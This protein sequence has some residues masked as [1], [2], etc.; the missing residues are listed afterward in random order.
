MID[1]MQNERG[2]TSYP[3]STFKFLTT[4]TW[5]PL[6]CGTAAILVGLIYPI[7]DYYFAKRI[8]EKRLKF[9]NKPPKSAVRAAKV[10][11]LVALK[12]DKYILNQKKQKDL[13]IKNSSSSSTS[14]TLSNN[15]NIINKDK[16]IKNINDKIKRNSNFDD[17]SIVDN[18]I[19]RDSNTHGYECNSND[20]EEDDYYDDEYDDED[21]EDDEES[22]IFTPTG[23]MY[24]SNFGSENEEEEDE[25]EDD[26]E[27]EEEEDGDD[28]EEEHEE[29]DVRI[30]DEKENSNKFI[31]KEIWTNAFDDQWLLEH[32][33]EDE[34]YLNDLNY[35][36][37]LKY[38]TNKTKKEILQ[39]SKYSIPK[40]LENDYNN[41]YDE[42]HNYKKYRNYK[43]KNRTSI[44]SISNSISSNSNS[45][46]SYSFKKNI[47][48]NQNK[49][50]N[51]M[52]ECSTLRN[53][54]QMANHD[55]PNIVRCFGCFLGFNYAAAKLPWINSVQLS[56]TL[57]VFAIILWYWFDKTIHGFIFSFFVAICGT[58]MAQILVNSGA[59][60]FTKADFLGVRSW[61][62]AIMY[63]ASICF[64]CMGR[65]LEVD[66]NDFNHYLQ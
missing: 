29:N 53:L 3:P 35:N 51:K 8:L 24:S 64:G 48:R 45:V 62:P 2:I 57:A 32:E 11:S 66:F 40:T 65:Q 43:K 9:Y 14:S 27:E 54:I 13:N 18:S 25:E 19:S 46:S 15:A 41:K 52:N 56:V 63:S 36:N 12:L 23:M 59:Y 60:S 37:N 42:Y 38:I 1:Q 7:L 22:I 31:N 44:S 6:T 26:E 47:N 61:F 17:E 49:N 21:Y 5:V 30:E 50:K 10:A 34:K 20:N 16:D 58:W 4:A 55:W 33:D 28:E 39:I